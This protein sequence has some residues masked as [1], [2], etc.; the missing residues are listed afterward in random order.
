MTANGPTL[1]AS[2]R[3]L[4]RSTS[5]TARSRPPG[6]SPTHGM[7][8]GSAAIAM[9]ASTS[10]ARTGRRTSRSVRSKGHHDRPLEV[11]HDLVALVEPA[12]PDGDDAEART[13]G[14]LALG[15]D[16]RLGTDRVT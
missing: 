7:T 14:R 9:N 13:R 10:S 6:W 3:R 12:R 15:Q 5:S 4:Q 1:F 8:S 16:L 2:H 11:D